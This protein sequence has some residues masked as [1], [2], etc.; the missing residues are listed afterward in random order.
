[1]VAGTLG[2]AAALADPLAVALADP[3]AAVADVALGEQAVQPLQL[4]LS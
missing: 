1:V 3:L 4:E 2:Q